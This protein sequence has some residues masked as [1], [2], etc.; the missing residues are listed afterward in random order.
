MLA[1]NPRVA[2]VAPAGIFDPDGLERGR[3][4][5]EDWGFRTVDGPHLHARHRYLAGTVAQRTDALCWALTEP[6]IDAVWFARGGF[7]TAHALPAIPWDQLDDRVVIGFSDA[8]ALL[9]AAQGRS[10][11]RTVHGPVLHS[12]A[13]LPDDPSVQALR[14]LLVDGRT[15]PLRGQHLC[16]P[17]RPAT[18]PLL[19]GNLTVLASLAGTPWALRARDAIVALEDVGEPPYRLDRALGQLV[20]SGA[21]DGVAGVA[22]GRFVRCPVPDDAN[23]TVRD[24]LA[25][26][27]DKLG[28]PV[29][30]GLPFGHGSANHAFEVGGMATLNADGLFPQAVS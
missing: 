17:R 5:L 20:A 9:V 10:R 26:R 4:V 19:G 8:T 30:A 6:G 18:G 22:L 28:V 14:G 21:L 23:W 29:V 24:V 15:G 27:L 2:V 13:D 16:G 25:D 7:G 3:Q 12:L 11:L 1:P